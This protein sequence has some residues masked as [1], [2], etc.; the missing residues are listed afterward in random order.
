MYDN[1]SAKQKLVA[2]LKQ[3]QTVLV[4]GAGNSH[5]VGYPLWPQLVESLR[6]KF[7]D[8]LTWAGDTAAM[9]FASAIVAELRK[10]RREHAYHNFLETTFEPPRDGSRQHDDLHV[11]L[12]RLPFC[13][14]T[15]TNYER[16]IESA[17]GEAFASRGIPHFCEEIDLCD[18]RPYRV[19]DF[20][21][22]LSAQ[23]PRWVLHLHGYYRNPQRLILTEED[24]VG[25]YGELPVYDRDG[26]T[27]NVNLDSLHRKVLWALCISHPLVFVGFSLEDGFFVH[28]LRV[29]R[30]DLQLGEDL[31]HFAIMHY[32]TDDQREQV[33]EKLRLLNT[34]PIFY[35]VPPVTAG[36]EPD[37]SG[38]KRLIYELAREVGVS[39]VPESIA[40]INQR[41]LEL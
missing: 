7:A 40:S 13:G 35:Y 28:I 31:Q 30:Q 1:D 19:L 2:A 18:E 33:A 9:T 38:L 12:V 3:E 11:A 20:F 15:T 29:L 5:L 37:H 6:T 36:Q 22:S 4:A 24:Y 17:I 8:H 32:T 21:R 25:K 14:F 27:L 39:V 23:K 34:R 41:M 26:R 16:V 10:N